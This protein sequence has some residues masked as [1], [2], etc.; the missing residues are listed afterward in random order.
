M[1]ER[2]ETKLVL[3]T[4]E[5]I[6]SRVAGGENDIM[7]ERWELSNPIP[8]VRI[9][10]TWQIYHLIWLTLAQDEAGRYLIYRSIDL[11]KYELVHTHDTEI[12][13]L[14]WLDDGH[15]IFSAS[16]G[17]WRTTNTGLDWSEIDWEYSPIARSMVPIGIEEGS[18]ILVAYGQDHKLYTCVY[19]GGGWAEVYDTTQIWDYKWY[20]AIAGGPPGILAGAGNK[21]LRSTEVGKPGSWKVIQEVDGIIKEIVVSNQSNI[22]TFLVEVEQPD[23]GSKLYWSYDLGDSL[24]ADL[25]RINPATSVQSV[26][27]TGKSIQNAIFAVVGK[28]STDGQYTIK[29]ISEEKK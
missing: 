15:A 28:R 12:H 7:T 4:N 14:F 6:M 22:P 18:W 2:E 9:I 19:P 27:P 21:L 25:T 8:G 1:P 3:S 5:R 29:V 11:K 26:I 10:N 16:D 24:I 23:G 17:W 13:N 20:P